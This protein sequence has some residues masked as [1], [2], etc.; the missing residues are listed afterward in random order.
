MFQY[1]GWEKVEVKKN[2][3]ACTPVDSEDSDLESDDDEERWIESREI[4]L[5]GNVDSTPNSSSL[6]EVSPGLYGLLNNLFVFFFTR[7]EI[8]IF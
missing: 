3:Y 1:Y 8:F 7:E 2:S 4:F 5:N 6:K